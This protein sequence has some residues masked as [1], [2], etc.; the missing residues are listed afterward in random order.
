MI[1]ICS[2]KVLP[3]DRRSLSISR[4]GGLGGV[5][6][7]VLCQYQSSCTRSDQILVQD[8]LKTVFQDLDFGPLFVRKQ[9][10]AN[11]IK[12]LKGVGLGLFWRRSNIGLSCTSQWQ[13][14]VQDA[15][16]DTPV[17]RQVYRSTYDCDELVLYQDHTV[18]GTRL[19]MLLIGS[20]FHASAS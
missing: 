19:K 11:V 3:L 18:S 2:L 10:L 5:H 15:W 8:D 12:R 16:A 14:L 7:T 20:Q 4:E 6:K 17:L 13:V 9:P 1:R